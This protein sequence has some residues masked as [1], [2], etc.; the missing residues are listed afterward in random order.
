MDETITSENIEWLYYLLS[1]LRLDKNSRDAAVPGLNRSKAYN[2]LVPLPKSKKEQERIVNFIL[3]RS[4]RIDNQIEKIQQQIKYM[5]EYKQ[6]L[7]SKVVTGKVAPPEA[8]RC[9]GVEL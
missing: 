1:V 9:E 8:G 5:K 4:K 3:N 7:I 2:K 6:S